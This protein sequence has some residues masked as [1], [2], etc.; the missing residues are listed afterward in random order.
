LNPTELIGWTS[1]F[2]LPLTIIA[3]FSDGPCKA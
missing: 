2:I 3:A 1:S